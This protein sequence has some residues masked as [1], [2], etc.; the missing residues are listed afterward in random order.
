MGLI[1][2]MHLWICLIKYQNFLNLNCFRILGNYSSRPG[3]WKINYF[4]SDISIRPNMSSG[5]VASDELG[6]FWNLLVPCRIL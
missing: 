4:E 6:F 5:G 1:S 3:T 2:D